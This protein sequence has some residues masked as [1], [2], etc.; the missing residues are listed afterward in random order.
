MTDSDQSS[1]TWTED[2]EAVEHDREGCKVVCSD[3]GDDVT[4]SKGSHD[5]MTR[6][7][8]VKA[9]GWKCDRCNNVLPANCHGP[10]APSYIAGMTGLVVEFRGGDRE[11]VPVSEDSV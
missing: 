3:C 2:P 6:Q 7:G 9:H 5:L 11:F 10:E 4:D 1:L 8:M